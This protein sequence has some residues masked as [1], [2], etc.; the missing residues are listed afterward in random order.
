MPSPTL[1]AVTGAF[2]YTGKYVTRR[3]LA[4]GRQVITLTGRPSRPNPFGAQVRAL[5]FNFDHPAALA[6]RLEGVD[7][8]YNTYWVRFS[9]G[10]NTFQRA[11]ENTQTLFNAA[12][13]AGVR[14]VVHVGITNPSPDSTLPYF[15]GKGILEG[16]LARSGLS[17]AI[18]RPTVIFGGE[19]GEDILINNIAW[20]LRRFPVFAVMGKGGY[21]LQ[22]V[23]V[24]D[25]AGIMVGAGLSGEN[26]ILDAVGPE[27]YTF[28]ELVRLIREQVGSQARIVH[29]S[30][31]LALRFAQLIGLLVND[32]VLTRDEVVGLMAGLLVSPDRPTGHTRLSEWLAANADRVGVRYTSELRRHY[33]SGQESKR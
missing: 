7:T 29:V 9:H 26:A 21:R 24:E 23:Y 6:R 25:L 4:M 15:R 20:L 28:E 33:R 27:V 18:I 14:R 17:Y 30:P 1:D 19:S 31:G 12:R 11:V 10:E 22:P 13:D 3:L 16:A 8:L 2:G 32:V 5:P